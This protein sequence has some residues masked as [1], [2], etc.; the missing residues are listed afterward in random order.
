VP[1]KFK[2]PGCG[3]EFESYDELI[4]HVVEKHEAN[5]QICGAKTLTR[6]ELIKHNK[7]VHGV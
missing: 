4:D 5:C 3:A 2:C 1:E 6:E 7:E